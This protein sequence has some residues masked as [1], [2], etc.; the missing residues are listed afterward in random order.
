VHQNYRS[1]DMPFSKI[2]RRFIDDFE[3]YLRTDGNNAQ[4]YANKM[5]QIFKKVYRIAVDNRW[6]AHNAFA[7]RRLSYKKVARPYLSSVEIN[8]LM[9]SQFTSQDSQ[10]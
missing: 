2:T 7:G 5:L 3:H 1:N 6:T 9:N 4:N 10:Q 8:T